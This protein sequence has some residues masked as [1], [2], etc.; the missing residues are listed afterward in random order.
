MQ[1]RHFLVSGVEVLQLGGQHWESS[2]WPPEH[3]REEKGRFRLHTPAIDS[4]VTAALKDKSYGG[5]VEG[6]VIAL[7]VAD[8]SA[9]PAIT[10]VKP[11]TAPSFKPKYKELWCF[12]K[13]DWSRI[14]GMTLREQYAA[15]TAAVLHAVSKFQLSGRKPKGFQVQEF[16]ADLEATLQ[17]LKPSKLTR[18]ALRGDA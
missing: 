16:S 1:F 12:A 6:V 18:A 10:F 3:W 8:F 4:L 11:E 14:K 13:L 7:E 5:P 17:S 15:Y 2:V 9:W